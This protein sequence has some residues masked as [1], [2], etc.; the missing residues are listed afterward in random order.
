MLAFKE[1]VQLI[2]NSDGQLPSILRFVVMLQCA[3]QSILTIFF[4]IGIALIIMYR[5]NKKKGEKNW[6]KYLD[7][8]KQKQTLFEA[9][10]VEDIDKEKDA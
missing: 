3:Y 7:T 4:F 1:R 5:R 10:R 6:Y 8:I 9:K 2:W